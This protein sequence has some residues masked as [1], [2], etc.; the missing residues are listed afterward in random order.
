MVLVHGAVRGKLVH[1]AVVHPGEGTLSRL[2]GGHMDLGSLPADTLR[3]LKSTLSFTPP[4]AAAF[5]V[6]EALKVLLGQERGLG[7]GELLLVDAGAM[8][9]RKL[10]V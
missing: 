8:T 6:S 1:V 10:V 9:F 5:E 4:L 3:S 7:A 2:Y